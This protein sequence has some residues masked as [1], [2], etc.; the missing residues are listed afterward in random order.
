MNAKIITKI[1]IVKE[2][3]TMSEATKYEK[4]DSNNIRK[5]TRADDPLNKQDLQD[6]RSDWD[7]IANMSDVIL[8][9]LTIDAVGIKARAQ[10]KVDEIDAI[11]D[12]FNNTTTSKSIDFIDE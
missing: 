1:N 9:K 5:W 8:G 3:M 6:E 10:V 2:V 11:L 7:F 4:V 12:L